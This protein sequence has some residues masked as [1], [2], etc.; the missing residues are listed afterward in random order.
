MK[1]N[2]Y[3]NIIARHEFVLT[4]MMSTGPICFRIGLPIVLDK[5]YSNLYKHML[6]YIEVRNK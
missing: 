6:F 4:H 1:T 2:I 5:S 3:Y